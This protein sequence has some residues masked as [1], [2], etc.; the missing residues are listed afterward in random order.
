MLQIYYVILYNICGKVLT[1]RDG[2]M[3][4]I[5]VHNLSKTDKHGSKLALFNHVLADGNVGDHPR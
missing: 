1:S 5:M 3:I 2:N 4:K